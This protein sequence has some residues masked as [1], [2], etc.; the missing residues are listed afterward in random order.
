MNCSD[1]K[2]MISEHVAGELTPELKQEMEA[3]EKACAACQHAVEEWRQ[4]ETLLRSSL[5]AEDPRRS[6]FL[7]IPPR[8]VR[9]LEIARTGF[10][11]ASMAAVAACLLLFVVLRPAVHLDR[12]Q[13]S[14]SFASTPIESAAV[15]AQPLS[16][17][18][19]QAWVQEAFAQAA[20]QSPEKMPEAGALKPTPVAA[21]QANRLAQLAVQIQ[22]LKENQLSLWQQ[23]QQHGLYLQSSWHPPSGQIDS[24]PKQYSNQP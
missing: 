10:G 7:P 19:V 1:F 2:D 16:Q 4:M 13:L 11:F 5:P 24:T 15:S 23:V 6:F 18:Q 3:H 14:V 22:L 17:A 21:E 20:S 8:R 9:W 12:R